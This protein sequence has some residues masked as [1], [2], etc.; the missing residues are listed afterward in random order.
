MGR[1]FFRRFV[2]HRQWVENHRALR[3]LAHLLDQPALWHLNRHSASKGVACGMFW[4]FIPLPCQT[5]MACLSAIR[6]RCNVALAVAVSWVAWF[7]L[8]PCYYL[9]YR[10]GLLIMHQSPIQGFFDNFHISWHW[11]WTHRD[12]LAPFFVGSIPVAAA[13]AAGAYFGTQWLWRWML[14]RRI[15]QRRL[16]RQDQTVKI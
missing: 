11:F 4:A 10:I 6:L 8:F 13:L 3:G 2:P 5:L 14:V 12:R 9:S 7:V 15:R 1:D 16:R